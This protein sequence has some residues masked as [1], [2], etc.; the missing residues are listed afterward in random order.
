MI[1]INLISHLRKENGSNIGFEVTKSSVFLLDP[2]F[3]EVMMCAK[4]HPF[5]KLW[6]QTDQTQTGLFCTRVWQTCSKCACVKLSIL[7]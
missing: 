3:V 1:V 7:F 2:L 6:Y 4:N 5:C